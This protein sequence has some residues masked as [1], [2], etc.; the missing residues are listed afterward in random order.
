MVKKNFLKSSLIVLAVLAVALIPTASVNAAIDNRDVPTLAYSAHVQGLGW[1]GRKS[2]G[3]SVNDS[4]T[5]AGT[6]GQSKRVEALRVSFDAP[7][8]VTLK[9]NAHIQGI[10]WTGWTEITED[11]QIIGTQGQSK[12]LEAIKFSV[13]G[14]EGF[15][16]K[17]RAHVQT[18]GWMDWVTADESESLAKIVGTEGESKR[19]ESLQILILND[20][21][22]TVFD[23]RQQAIKELKAY[24]NPTEFTMNAKLLAKALEDGITAIEGAADK[25]AINVALNTAKAD[26]EDTDGVGAT[27]TKGVLNDR[28]VRAA[29]ADLCKTL[30]ED[31]FIKQDQLDQALIAGELKGVKLLEVPSIKQAIADAKAEL[32]NKEEYKAAD[33][34]DRSGKYFTEV[35]NA[36]KK[37]VLNY[38]AESLETLYNAEADEAHDNKVLTKGSYN[39]A[40]VGTTNGLSVNLDEIDKISDDDLHTKVTMAKLKTFFNTKLVRDIEITTLRKSYQGHLAV[41]DSGLGSDNDVKH[42]N[43]VISKNEKLQ[44]AGLLEEGVAHYYDVSWVKDAIQDGIDD[45][46]TAMNAPQLETIFKNTKDNALAGLVRFV[47]KLRND[48]SGLNGTEKV[49]SDAEIT[50]INKV[51]SSNDL[52]AKDL[53]T[54]CENMI[55]SLGLN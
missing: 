53:V 21:Q 13:T 36:A 20:T 47:T 52:T 41:T 51:L 9:Y 35:Y 14:L 24:A 23:L 29:I 25:S 30:D 49:L 26:I 16:I 38:A 18:Y 28:Q 54:A 8:G 40:K 1:M 33:F 19:I 4:N 42:Y 31:Y 39:K 45:M 43:Q 27:D 32:Y 12:R 34:A 46:D 55:K 7:T 22:A 48:L 44:P 10:G 37:A 5:I 15:Q 3:T 17:Y 2:A 6:E 50:K 11:N